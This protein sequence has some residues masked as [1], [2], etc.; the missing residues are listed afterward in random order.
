MYRKPYRISG[1]TWS[2]GV[3]TLRHQF[4]GAEVSC[5]RSIRGSRSRRPADR[6]QYFVL[7]AAVSSGCPPPLLPPLRT[8]S[9]KNKQRERTRWNPR[10]FVGQLPMCCSGGRSRNGRGCFVDCGRH[11]LFTMS[12]CRLRTPIYGYWYSHGTFPRRTKTTR[13]LFIRRSAAVCILL[14]ITT[15]LRVDGICGSGQSGTV[16]NGGVENA[17][18]DISARYGKGGH[19]GNGQCGTIWQGWTLQEW[20]NQHDVARVDTGHCRSGQCGTVVTR[21]DNA[22]GKNVSKLA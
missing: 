11:G 5:G 15:E 21:V 1:V 2:R 20:T 14:S 19:W 10:L 8:D 7:I 6:L 12:K 3:R 22:G 18:V 17:G 4:C 16:K 13:S 9:A